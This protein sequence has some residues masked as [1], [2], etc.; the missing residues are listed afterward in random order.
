MVAVVRVAGDADRA[1]HLERQPVDHERLAQG[2]LEDLGHRLGVLGAEHVG[3]QHAELVAA[4]AGD[5]VGGAQRGLQPLGDLLEEHVAVVMAERVVDLLEVVE[6]HDHHGRA[7][8]AALGG[9]HGLLD[10]VAEEH[11]VREAGE[12]VVQRLVLLGDRL[13]AAAVDRQQRQEQQRQHGEREVGGDDEHRREPEQQAG[14]RGLEEEVGGEVAPEADALGERDR[15]GDEARVERVEDEGG[16]DDAREVAGHEAGRVVQVREAAERRQHD[17]GGGDREDV[18]RG[19]EGDPLGRLAADAVGEDRAER[20]GHGGGCRAVTDQQREGE[21]VGG[22]DLALG[23]AQDDLERGQLG[24]DRAG[25]EQQEQL[26]ALGLEEVETARG[27][28]DDQDRR[29]RRR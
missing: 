25:H 1:A 26:G 3:Q 18:L 5:G 13:A 27:D 21:G 7:A 15:A 10:A 19:V 9:A 24:H 8:V 14:G 28:Q 17:A 29:C 2:G 22:G 4:E 20:E 6:V 23:G 12:R 16:R 11:A